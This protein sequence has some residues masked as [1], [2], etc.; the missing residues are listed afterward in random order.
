[1]VPLVVALVVAAPHEVVAASILGSG[2]ALL[3]RRQRG[4]KLAFN[5]S[6][7]GWGS[8]FAAEVHRLVLDDADP[9]S[10]HGAVAVLV[11]VVLTDLVSA[12]A[13]TL[14]IWLKAGS[15][16]DGVLR[17]A[18]SSGLFIA[19]TSTCVGLLVLVLLHEEPAAL[20]LLLAVAA[21]L[22]VAD[23]GHAA[24]SQQHARVERLYRF[25]R[26]VGRTSGT[27]AVVESVLREARDVM[28][29]E[30][31]DLRLLP[32]GGA[33]ARWYRLVGDGEM[34]DLDAGEGDG[35]PELW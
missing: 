7:F 27:G 32:H 28:S 26:R 25:T 24:R 21:T 2:T 34:E 6:P 22:A 33:P 9:I 14:V 30:R 11:A 29:A 31:A 23:H 4:L 15:Y 18:V 3:L 5:L 17:E 16:D 12:A 1:V 20:V 10:A 8:A 35:A 19:V 13:L